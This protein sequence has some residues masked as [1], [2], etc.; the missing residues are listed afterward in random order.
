MVILFSRLSI[1]YNFATLF[2]DAN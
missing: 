1:I 2:A